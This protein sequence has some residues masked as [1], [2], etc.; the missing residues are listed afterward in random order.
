MGTRHHS[1]KIADQFGGID[2]ML[3]HKTGFPANQVVQHAINNCILSQFTINVPLRSYNINLALG[4][5]SRFPA[6]EVMRTLC[7]NPYEDCS[8]LDMWGMR[9]AVGVLFKLELKPYGYTFVAKGTASNR[10]AYVE[11]E[12]R[13]YTRLEAL[14]GQRVPVHLGLARL[15][16]GYILPGGTRAVHMMLMSWAGER[17]AGAGLDE[18]KFKEERKHPFECGK[19]ASMS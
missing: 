6:D 2:F 5:N 8:A 10:L 9:G 15:K 3:G 18:A 13:I 19:V 14:Q 11:N 7:Q 17:A 4:Y 1:L 12:G 16:H